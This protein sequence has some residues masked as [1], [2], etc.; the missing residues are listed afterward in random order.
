MG[1]EKIFENLDFFWG[2]GG[3]GAYFA[4]PL[5][6]KGQCSHEFQNLD[7]SNLEMLH[8]KNGSNWPCCFQEFEN[9]K[10]LTHNR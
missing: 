4:Q 3:R 2:G 8:S 7:F 9:V 6:P 10:L 5:R 1:D